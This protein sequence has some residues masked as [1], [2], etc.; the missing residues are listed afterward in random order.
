MMN[1][2]N[3]T[4]PT[5][6]GRRSTSSLLVTFVAALLA[7]IVV[8]LVS[9]Q[10]TD[11]QVEGGAWA[12]GQNVYGQ[13]G[14]GTTTQRNAPVRVGGL[15][16]GVQDIEGGFYHSLALKIDGTG[17]T[18][19][20]VWGRNDF[21]Q[22]GVGT[23]T[24]RRNAPVQVGGL[25]GVQDIAAGHSHSLAL[26]SNGTVWAWGKNEYRQLGDGTTTDRSAPVQVGG[27][28]DVKAIS[29]GGQH[30]LALKNDDTLWAWG[31]NQFGELGD[32]T[33]TNR[34]TPVQVLSEVKA[35][36]GGQLYTLA[37]KKDGT[38]LAWGRN[39]FGQLG[40]GTTTDSNTPV[41][42]L[43]DVKAIGT[44]YAHSLALKNDG[45]LW[46]WGK[47]EFG[48]LGD[49]TTTQRNT[50]VQVRGFSDEQAI[51]DGGYRHSLALKSDGTVWAWGRNK[52][53]QLGAAG[54]ITQRNAPVQVRGISGVQ[55]VDAG[56]N[57][58]L[59]IR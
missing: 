20:W 4:Q 48:E 56:G 29:S 13:L 41:Q 24:T 46:A 50:P 10:R 30:G 43:S 31:K 25:S 23:T 3:S 32:G 14:D 44:G 26:K 1:T 5:P 55:D 12:W 9:V 53:G 36:A 37:L 54:T 35:V 51:I 49:G 15:S 19:V 34:S 52:F 40:T 39:N 21:G 16:S 45:T 8:L 22:L 57:H 58:N 59:A 7:A 33:T 18:T 2:L 27:L 17:E 42:V 47:N 6:S 38:V 11:A 28:S